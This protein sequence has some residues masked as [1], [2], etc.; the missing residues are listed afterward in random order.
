MNFDWIKTRSDFDIEK[1]AVIDPLKGTQ[2][3]YQQLNIRADHMAHYLTEQGLRQGDVIGVFAPND[4][5]LL[6]LLFASF[7]MGAVFLPINWRLNPTEIAAVVQ[8]S[9]LK[10]YFT[11]KNI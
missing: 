7:K 2:W 6:D 10:F 9:G 1:P 4:V 8:D 3:S 11:P 5:V